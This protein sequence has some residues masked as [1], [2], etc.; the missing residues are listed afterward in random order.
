MRKRIHMNQSIDV[1]ATDE[2]VR[3]R[4]QAYRD[5]GFE[6]R[7]MPHI[8]FQPAMHGC[9][10]PKC[11]FRIAGIDFQLELLGDDV[12]YQRWLRSWWKGPGLVGRCPGCGQFVLFTMEQKLIVE[13]PGEYGDSLLPDDW[14]ERAYLLN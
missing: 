4:V 12:A 2:Q 10:W 5:L 13:D 1:A 9:P 14:Y 11:N 8:V 7:A 6:R 3:E